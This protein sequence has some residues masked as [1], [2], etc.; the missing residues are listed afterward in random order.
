MGS[1]VLLLQLQQPSNLTNANHG[2]ASLEATRYLAPSEMVLTY[3]PGKPILSA[4]GDSLTYRGWPRALSEEV[5]RAY[6][7]QDL[8]HRGRCTSRL[9]D[10][11]Y[12][13]SSLFAAAR[14]AAPRVVV[15][16]F[17]TNDARGSNWR[18]EEHF[19]SEMSAL[20]FALF[21]LPSRPRLLLLIPPPIHNMYLGFR[22]DV[23]NERLPEL[24]PFIAARFGVQVLPVHTRF[25]DLLHE[26]TPHSHLYQPDGVHLKPYGASIIASAVASA[27]ERPY[28]HCTM[29]EESSPYDAAYG[30][31]TGVQRP[32]NSAAMFCAACLSC[33]GFCPQCESTVSV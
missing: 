5:Q 13:N 2:T 1:H 14:A 7:V 18:G 9:S 24:L 20:I 8:G 31:A 29:P 33:S 26:G 6:H 25:W 11:S 19:K 28:R 12:W 30:G 17:G 21:D 23:I 3:P 10:A 22:A 32:Y 27:L 15:V 16:M 4:L